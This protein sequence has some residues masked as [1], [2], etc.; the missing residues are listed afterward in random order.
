[1][2]ADL[3]P[4]LR[5]AIAVYL[6]QELLDRVPVLKSADHS[7]QAA[8][9]AAL[10]PTVVLAGEYIVCL[11][12]IAYEMFFV[13]FGDVTVINDQ[14]L[15]LY[16]L[17]AGS[18]FG[19]VSDSCTVCVMYLRCP[20]TLASPFAPPSITQNLLL[21]RKRATLSYRA[22]TNCELYRLTRQG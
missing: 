15:V 22:A 12:D 11:G 3:S 2:L 18:F 6:N 10:R 4:P 9:V 7:F 8:I 19:E 13:Q 14:G 21:F 16:T 5:R 20:L 17:G 1:M